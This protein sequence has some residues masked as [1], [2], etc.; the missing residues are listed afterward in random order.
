MS[1]VSYLLQLG[2]DVPGHL[3]G[4]VVTLAALACPDTLMEV[5]AADLARA[6]ACH[7]SELNGSGSRGGGRRQGCG[8]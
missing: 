6:R 3:S 8:G 5:V 2:T 1:G 4:V 7:R